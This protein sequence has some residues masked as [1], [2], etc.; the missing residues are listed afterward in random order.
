MQSSMQG[1]TSTVDPNL[2]AFLLSFLS[3]HL[4][5]FLFLFLFDFP[6]FSGKLR[7]PRVSL[8]KKKS[9]SGRVQSR[10]PFP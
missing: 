8:D 5:L 10:A 2:V 9:A 3:S 7:S 6:L 4:F 1:I